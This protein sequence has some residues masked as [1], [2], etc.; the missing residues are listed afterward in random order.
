MGEQI[1]AVLALMGAG[2]IFW[3]A[4]VGAGRS[5]GKKISCPSCRKYGMKS[6]GGRYYKNGVGTS[7]WQ[8]P[9]CGYKFSK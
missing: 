7:D 6:K 4:T 3:F 9:H 5:L 8:C 1:L 2:Y